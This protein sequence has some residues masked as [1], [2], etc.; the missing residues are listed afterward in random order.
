MTI[1][2]T[3]DSKKDPI[4]AEGDRLSG[5][6][7]FQLGRATND[8]PLHVVFCID[9]SPSMSGDRIRTAREGLARALEELSSKDQFAVCGFSNNASEIVTPTSGLRAD[10]YKADVRA[11]S[12]GGWGTDIIAGAR[13][14]KQMLQEMP[15]EKAITW[16]VLITDGGDSV[17]HSVLR[18]EFGDEG[19]TIYTA[20]IGNY[21]KDVVK[22]TAEL[23]QGEW[24]AIGQPDELQTFFRQRVKEARDV[25]AINPELRLTPGAY[26][27]IKNI[28]YTL[29][30]QQSTLEPETEGTERI[31]NLSD[32]N[33]SKPPTVRVD[34]HVDAVPQVLE[35]LTATLE[36][37]DHRTTDTIEVEVA[38][39]FIAEEENEGDSGMAD[40]AVAEAIE[41][42][43]KESPSAGKAVIEKFKQDHTL[44]KQK[45]S[46]AENTI[47]KLA[48]DHSGETE[49]E[50]TRVLGKLDDE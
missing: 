15:N 7:D 33:A 42:A 20:G 6:I 40:L 2:I 27:E 38:P 37:Q 13:R 17:N 41:T 29:G 36:T 5:V 16:I 46:E 49:E 19:I 25:V 26:T 30:D 45:V 12:S 3:A 43:L 34:L 48:K 10:Q 22:N 47:D 24:Q 50:A 28:Y 23:T 21:N 14:S 44:D 9:T 39:P 1:G 11:L 35:I 8:I 31:I 32:L 18:S 4:K